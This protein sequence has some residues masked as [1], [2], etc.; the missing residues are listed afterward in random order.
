MPIDRQELPAFPVDALPVWLGG[1]VQ[2]LADETQTPV[3]LAG[4]LVLAVL[5]TGAQRRYVVEIRRGWREQLCLWV[6]PILNSGERK[7]SVFSSVFAPVYER[8]AELAAASKADR[9]RA[10]AELKSAEDRLSRAIKKAATKPSGDEATAA[11]CARDE[12]AAEVERL[13][14]EI[15]PAADLLADDVTPERF[16]ML[17]AENGALTIASA[18]GGMFGN[19]FGRYNNKIPTIDLLLKSHSGDAATVD[20]VSR[21]KLT[22]CDPACTVALAVQPDVLVEQARKQEWTERGG[23]A[24]FLYAMP[25]AKVGRRRGH[26]QP[27]PTGVETIYRERMLELLPSRPPT[28]RADQPA[29]PDVLHLDAE[30]RAALE[31]FT[32]QHEPRLDPE[33]GDLGWCSAWGSKFRAPSLASPDFFSSPS[34]ARAMSLWRPCSARSPSHRTLKRTQSRRSRRPTRSRV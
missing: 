23:S 4:M 33:T 18:E 20:R 14:S 8:Q 30:A 1:Y 7:S 32:E 12:A 22:I 2:A 24:R 34:T 29:N 6:L 5:A 16:G 25:K 26:G 28:Q 10:H 31:A 15:P 13:R 9:A 27:M 19:F 17:L 21:E 3:D 11:E